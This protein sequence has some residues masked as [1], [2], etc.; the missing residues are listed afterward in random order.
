MP[1]LP[2]DLR[3]SLKKRGGP[4]YRIELIR[5]PNGKRFWVRRDGVRSSVVPEATA[6]EFAERIRQW[7]LA[8]DGTL[9]A[10]PARSKRKGRRREE[11]A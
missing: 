4:T 9:P 2:A 5:Q 8:E 11:F 10:S 3:I 1:R 6:T 7:I